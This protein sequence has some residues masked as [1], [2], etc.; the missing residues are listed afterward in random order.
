MR[1][2]SNLSVAAAA[3]AA[4]AVAAAPATAHA[5]SPVALEGADERTREAIAELLPDRD[6]PETLFEAERLA[7]EAAARA[8]AWF[9]A[10]GYYQAEVEPEAQADPPLARLRLTPGRRFALG[11][12]TIGYD[13]P[14]PVET[15]QAAVTEAIKRAPLGQPARAAAVL[16]AEAAAVAALQTRGY[17]DAEAGERRVIVD[18]AD[19][20]MTPHYRFDAGALARLGVLRANPDDIFRPGFLEAVR[21]WEEGDLYSPEALAQLRRDVAA[22]G[23]VSRVSTRLE[24]RGDGSDLRDVV[25]DIDRAQRRAIELGGGYSTSEG[26]G[27][28]AEW[29]WRNITR[30]ADTLTLGV[31]LGEMRQG[32]TAELERPHAAGIG[33]TVRFAAGATREETEAFERSGVAIS[34]SV[35]AAQRLARGL[36]Y[37][38]SLAADQ[39]DDASGGAHTVTLSGFGELRRD[40]TGNPLD[41]R[42][43]D[44]LEIRLEPSYALG[45]SNI[46]F[47][48]ATADARTYESRGETQALTFAARARA[49]YVLAVSGSDENIPPD[50]RFYA[51]G[52][53]SVRGYAYNSIYPEARMIAGATPG[54]QGLLEL[55]AEARYRLD[56][57][58]LGGLGRGLGAVGFID[59]G[60]AFDSFDEAFDFKWGLG[61][62]ARYDLGFA[63]LRVDLALPLDPGPNDPDFALYVSLGQA[64]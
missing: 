27:V 44:V 5:E 42:D 37:G 24:P 18:H 59:G 34:A 55:S 52:G 62:G 35:D 16:E 41:A 48:R 57:D 46:A 51:G 64:F 21:N 7:E 39:Y 23:A 31:T 13:D 25:L 1:A 63:P 43:G 47:V 12:A 14:A 36:S 40:S 53:G 29:T 22:T 61:V 58:A 45:E 49:G 26:A 20:T 56:A 2:L 54:G 19:A 38:V 32:L 8:T 6:P 30:R 50:R 60:N 17:P 15:A 33:R 11:G 4:L 28:E 10:E 3:G 9:R